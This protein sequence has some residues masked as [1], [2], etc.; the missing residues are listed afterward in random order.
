MSRPIMDFG[1][2]VFFMQIYFSGTS[3][4]GRPRDPWK[5]L[6]NIMGISEDGDSGPARKGPPRQHAI[7]Y[8]ATD[9]PACSQC[10]ALDMPF[11]DTDCQ[12]CLG[13]LHHE[14]T[15]VPEIFAI[16]RQWVPRT[17]KDI[18]M[19]VTEVKPV[20]LTRLGWNILL[21]QRLADGFH[22]SQKL[23]A[24]FRS[25]GIRAQFTSKKGTVSEH[26]K[27][28]R[29][30]MPWLMSNTSGCASLVKYCT[31]TYLCGKVWFA[32]P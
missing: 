17:Q 15:S 7:V 24:S 25:G 3:H 19:L 32:M 23:L 10:R 26:I 5:H 21:N 31:S 22:F 20:S 1:R 8:Q 4:L 13:I 18:K 29:C 2:C 11:F 16:L 14:D 30:N 12:G 9:A 27:V 6:K 28:T